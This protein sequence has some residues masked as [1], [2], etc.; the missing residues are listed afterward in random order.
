MPTNDHPDAVRLGMKYREMLATQIATVLNQRRQAMTLDPKTGRQPVPPLPQVANEEENNYVETS[1]QVMGFLQGI[2]VS[3]P[4]GLE[5]LPP[6]IRRHIWMGAYAS[7]RNTY[8]DEAMEGKIDGK[9]VYTR[10]D[11]MAGRIPED[12]M[13][14]GSWLLK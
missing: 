4:A 9:P 10:E 2:G 12:L 14:S 7:A 11:M 1:A 3:T 5:S 13:K 6:D 8:Y